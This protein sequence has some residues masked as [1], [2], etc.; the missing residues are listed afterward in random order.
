LVNKDESIPK[1]SNEETVAKS[2]INMNHVKIFI[3][4]PLKGFT[5]ITFGHGGKGTKRQREFTT[6]NPYPIPTDLEEMLVIT[7]PLASR[8]AV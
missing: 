5:L 8:C 3:P 6:I 1:A 2:H 4:I 7:T